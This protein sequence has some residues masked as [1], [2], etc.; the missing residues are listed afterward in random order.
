MKEGGNLG[1][2]EIIIK[3]TDFVT[4]TKMNHI[5]EI[6]Y[7]EKMN[8]RQ[9]IKKLSSE[10][11]LV[12]DTGEIKEFQ[13]SE[14]RIE[15]IN[16]LYKTFKKLRYLINNNFKGKPNELF[17]TLTFGKDENKWRPS[18]GD[19]VFLRKCFKVFIQAIKRKYGSVDFVRVL[20][21]HEDGH[22]H[23][24][25]LLRFNDYK[26]I[27]ISSKQLE[28]YWKMGFV[29]IRSLKDV[30]NIGAYVSAYL[31]DIEL[32]DHTALDACSGSNPAEIIDKE[33]K[34]YI[35]GGRVKYYPSGVQIYNKSKGILEPERIK[36]TYEKAKKI[37][38]SG[39][40]T[41][42]KNIVIE[43]ED[44]SNSIRFESYNSHRL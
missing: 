13:H 38:G 39:Q 11:Y 34:K 12:L 21:P 4:V 36:M 10:K 8:T 25:V 27:F 2:T 22:A 37:A 26:K 44:F 33:G 15:N 42:E 5:T 24:H 16:S 28:D 30:D 40:P 3:P 17:I 32:N 9:N 6:Q 35:K 43:K 29:K 1:E 20:E 19:T 18:C 41:F 23:Y 7:M 31:T 14:K